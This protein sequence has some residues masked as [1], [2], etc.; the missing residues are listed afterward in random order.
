MAFSSRTRFPEAGTFEEVSSVLYAHT[1][2][3]MESMSSL[4]QNGKKK[5]QE[6]REIPQIDFASTISLLAGLP[7]P[8]GSMGKLVRLLV[9]RNSLK[10]YKGKVSGRETS[11]VGLGMAL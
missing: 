1:K 2:Y 7:I 8:Y 10:Q 3:K 4:L 6:L 5:M 9:S 11:V